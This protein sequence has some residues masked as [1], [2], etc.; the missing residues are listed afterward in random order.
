MISLYKWDMTYQAF[1]NGDI[2]QIQNCRGKFCTNSFDLVKFC[3][4]VNQ[5]APFYHVIN[6][7]Y[8]YEVQWGRLVVVI[9][10]V[11]SSFQNTTFYHSINM[12]INI[13]VLVIHF[14][15]YAAKSLF[16]SVLKFF[17][18]LSK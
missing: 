6:S 11:Q 10:F 2:W 9:K 17:V 3:T 5:Y 7:F 4:I 14:I 18:V 8:L 16:D 13:A 12:L 1:I 15:R